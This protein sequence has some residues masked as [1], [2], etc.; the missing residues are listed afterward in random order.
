[1]LGTG[2]G[3]QKG[4]DMMKMQMDVEGGN[5]VVSHLDFSHLLRH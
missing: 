2:P 3:G 5:G 1:V 4:A